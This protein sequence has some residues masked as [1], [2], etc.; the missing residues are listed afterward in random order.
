[1][2]QI[3]TLTTLLEREQAE[4]DA[5]RAAWEAAQRSAGEASAQAAQLV[6]Y[7][8]DYSTRWSQRF[9][10]QAS[11][12]IL[13][14]YHSFVDRL[15]QAV[16]QQN[17]VAA[18]AQTQCD[19]LQQQ[20]CQCEIRVASVQRLIERR[21]A[22]EKLHTDRREQKTLDEAAQ[23]QARARGRPFDAGLVTA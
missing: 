10:Q 8:S 5:A 11:I 19:A 22:A 2:T 23:R 14:C 13:R 7:R 16:A 6:S 12:E 18:R 1:M 17:H 20:L 15:D 9:S 21:I 3:Q 4:R